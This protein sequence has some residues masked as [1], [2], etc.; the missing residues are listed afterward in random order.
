MFKSSLIVPLT[1]KNELN[2]LQR[3]FYH[4]DQHLR[5][6][7]KIYQMSRITFRPR[8]YLMIKN[9]CSS[10]PLKYGNSILGIFIQ[11]SPR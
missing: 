3:E 10:T 6:K 8:I 5:G 2:D 1:F 11:N 4:I 7:A 9:Y